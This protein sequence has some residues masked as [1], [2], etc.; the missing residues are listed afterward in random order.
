MGCVIRFFLLK[1]NV[2]QIIVLVIGW[3]PP[4]RRVGD[5]DTLCGRVGGS[6]SETHTLC[7]LL[8]RHAE[9]ESLP[10]ET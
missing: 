3:T 7:N 9:R 4:C 1:R 10:P 2:S 6:G 5:G 8:D